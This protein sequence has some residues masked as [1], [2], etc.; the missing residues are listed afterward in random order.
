MCSNNIYLNFQNNNDL[1]IRLGVEPKTSYYNEC[2]MNYFQNPEK[3][4]NHIM[5]ELKNHVDNNYLKINTIN[6]D[7]NYCIEQINAFIEQKYENIIKEINIDH[8]IRL[9]DYY[10][11][12]TSNNLLLN[13]DKYITNYSLW[14]T[15][16]YNMIY[17]NILCA[18]Y[19]ICGKNE[20]TKLS[21]LIE[22]NWDKIKFEN[23]VNFSTILNKINFFGQNIDEYIN[24]YSNKFDQIE[25]ID[26]LIQYINKK[27]ELNTNEQLKKSNTN[28]QL[29]KSKY[30]FRFIINN[31]KSNGYL[32]Y[33]KTYQNIKNKYKKN[34]SLQLDKLIQTIKLDKKI[35]NYYIYLISMKN[36]NSTNRKVN[37]FL[38]K[39]KNYLEDIINSC[40]DNI[41]YR[42]ITIKQE[43]EKYKS[44]DLSS[45]N[46]DKS[47]FMVFKYSNIQQ[48]N[49]LNYNLNS[50]IEPY[51][52]IFKSYY[53][54]RYPDREIEFDLIKSTMIVKIIFNSKEYFIHLA[55]IQYIV[56]D[57]ILN[58]GTDGLEIKELLIQTNISLKHLDETI[59]SLLQVKL[60]KRTTNVENLLDMKLLINNDFER[61]HPKFSISSI[62]QPK[63]LIEINNEEKKEF[64]NDRNTII[65][66]NMYDY[67]KKNKTFKINQ[68]YDDLSK[69]KIP[70]KIDMEQIM[71]GIKIMSEK[72]DINKI[73]EEYYTFS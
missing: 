23:I 9:C 13:S 8:I 12:K 10:E 45:Y 36:L 47:T 53:K 26:K 1:L 69:N 48:T 49:I 2:F 41:N 18:E 14:R 51:F 65:L 30:D 21:I 5:N 55:L 31:L 62:I 16:Y 20:K 22:K 67:I 44:I 7:I 32:L 66:S 17:D 68:M 71:S 6:M 63:E 43:S 64:L 28:E 58:S 70:F 46:R 3:V 60:I 25:N 24:I 11:K 56:L 40:H 42:K 39:I 33:E 52:D 73:D 59:N 27:F 34:Q 37:E 15:L 57:K 61:D 19:M 35:I 4:N 38:I 72:E 54:A 29:K 50:Q